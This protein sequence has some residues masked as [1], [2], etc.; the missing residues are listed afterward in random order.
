MAAWPWLIIAG[1]FSA[2]AVYGRFGAIELGQVSIV[3]A[4]IQTSPLFVVF[5]SII[6]LR[7][8]E[9]ITGRV[10]LGTIPTVAGGVIVSLF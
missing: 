10:V 9:Q 4:L 2:A 3:I 1:L 8:L 6:F 7:E 5:I